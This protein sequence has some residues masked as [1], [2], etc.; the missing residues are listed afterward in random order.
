MTDEIH[1]NNDE[2]E[3]KEEIEIAGMLKAPEKPLPKRQMTTQHYE[4]EL[5]DIIN[6]SVPGLYDV[7]H[8]PSSSRQRWL[9]KRNKK[10][11]KSKGPIAGIDM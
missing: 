4:W 9:A 7:V 2:E 11:G 1:E 10:K 8:K 6:P 3:E 5:K